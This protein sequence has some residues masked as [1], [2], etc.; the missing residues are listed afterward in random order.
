MCKMNIFLALRLSDVVFILTINVIMP[1]INIYEQDKFHDR[2]SSAQS[3]ITVGLVLLIISESKQR[4]QILF[5]RSLW[6]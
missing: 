1:T 4:D 3:F 5:Q 2:L 6:E